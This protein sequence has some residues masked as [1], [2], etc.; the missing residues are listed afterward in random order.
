MLSFSFPGK[1]PCF[2]RSELR[3]AGR[4]PPPVEAVEPEKVLKG[5]RN[6]HQ[7]GN[8]KDQ[9][10]QKMTKIHQTSSNFIKLHQTSS[11]FR[12][13]AASIFLHHS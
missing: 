9:H 12:L 11:S 13:C 10:G 3:E 1:W 8:G 5:R 4:V 2:G 6:C 7:E